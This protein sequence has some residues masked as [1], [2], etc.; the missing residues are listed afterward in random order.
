[1]I[2]A[3]DLHSHV[4][5]HGVLSLLGAARLYNP[6]MAAADHG[7]LGFRNR[8]ALAVA[9]TKQLVSCGHH[10]QSA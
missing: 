8:H 4:G 2:L 7:Q 10:S 5:R 3:R 9:E 1:M 6:A